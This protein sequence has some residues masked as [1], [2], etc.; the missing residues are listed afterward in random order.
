MSYPHEIFNVPNPEIG[1]ESF[2]FTLH[3]SDLLRFPE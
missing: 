2:T 1:T 3:R